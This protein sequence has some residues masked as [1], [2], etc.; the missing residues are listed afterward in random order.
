[1]R[2]M[3]ISRSF[4]KIVL[5]ATLAP[6]A[7]ACDDF[8][9]VNE[10]P[11]SPIETT[12]PLSAKLPAA[13]VSTVNQETLQLNQIGAFWGGYWGTTNE[14]MGLFVDLKTYN[15][16]AIRHQRDGIKV[17]EDGYTTM[18]YYQLILDEAGKEGN[19]F[20]AGI[21]RIMLGWHFLRLVDFYNAV[22]FD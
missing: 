18:L 4:S 3:N 9:D 20:Y 21:A 17:W 15:G 1:M 7:S 12:L 19:S 13:I 14:G 10:N 8:L 16:P 2:I 5:A 6:V 11:N 22:P